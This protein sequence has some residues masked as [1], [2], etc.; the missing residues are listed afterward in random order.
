MRRG[1]RSGRAGPDRSPCVGR[2]SGPA[3]VVVH[4]AVIDTFGAETARRD[5]VN[6]ILAAVVDVGVEVTLMELDPLQLRFHK[7]PLENPAAEMVGLV[8]VRRTS[9]RS[10]PIG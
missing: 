1:A 10:L 6:S 7:S 2:G 8:G 9:R 3:Q 5:H 4:E